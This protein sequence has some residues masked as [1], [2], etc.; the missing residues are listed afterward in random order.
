MSDEEVHASAFVDRHRQVL[1]ELR[2]RTELLEPR[3]AALLAATATLASTTGG[4]YAAQPTATS[5]SD[6]TRYHEHTDAAAV[7]T[8]GSAL[9]SAAI[10]SD[11]GA[12][13]VAHLVLLLEK[14]QSILEGELAM[15]QR[16]IRQLRVLLR[17]LTTSDCPRAGTAVGV[18]P[19]SSLSCVVDAKQALT[20]SAT[21]SFP[22]AGAPLLDSSHASV[23]PNTAQHP[24]TLYHAVP[25]N[26]D[27][28][29]LPGFSQAVLAAQS[30]DLPALGEN[31]RG[32]AELLQKKESMENA[33]VLPTSAVAPAAPTAG[34]PPAD[35]S[36]LPNSAA[37]VCTVAN[38]L[39]QTASAA[40][41]PE[42]YSGHPPSVEQCAASDPSPPA[43]LARDS[44]REATRPLE[45]P[46][47][48]G[49]TTSKTPE[50]PASL[51]M[52]GANAAPSEA[53]PTE[54]AT[55]KP[56][57]SQGEGAAEVTHPSPTSA[58]SLEV[59]VTSPE[60]RDHP[61][62]A[63]DR[64][65]RCNSVNHAPSQPS[66]SASSEGG[67]AAAGDLCACTAD[68]SSAETESDCGMRRGLHIEVPPP[69]FSDG[70]ASLPPLA[71]PPP[72]LPVPPSTPQSSN[73]SVLPPSPCAVALT[74][75][76][77]SC[78]R[79]PSGDAS[80]LRDQLVPVT[81][82]APRA[83]SPLPVLSPSALNESVPILAAV[84]AE[85]PCKAAPTTDLLMAAIDTAANP[86]DTS[87]A[88]VTTVPVTTPVLSAVYPT[89]ALAEACAAS[90]TVPLSQPST[91]VAGGLP[92]TPA[93]SPPSLEQQS[94]LPPPNALPI[95]NTHSPLQQQHSVDKATPGDGRYTLRSDRREKD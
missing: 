48:S 66:P 22:H 9:L 17:R 90:L 16:R 14:Q 32:S 7:A 1:S 53:A 44:M 36:A 94:A 76:P 55:E 5:A 29:G 51:D 78:E 21:S 89:N 18:R 85:G 91:P 81:L 64:E 3:D 93:S 31:G 28:T 52:L 37:A 80:A 72:L 11:G 2:T 71:A 10:P 77:T 45:V 92:P 84:A 88:G 59:T 79:V 46:T 60:L 95:A 50:E 30:E 49:I 26:R 74:P 65:D 41:Q 54:I 42:P 68:T 6:V 24:C 87:T 75:L 83:A 39:E 38:S 35:T 58:A 34:K 70:A 56:E 20:A 63:V 12:A 69:A 15:R 86:T 61:P 43:A 40:A 62:D 13:A 73:A 4:K 27:P 47:E 82:P 57:R 67:L 33:G 8:S 25:G 23:P 19:L